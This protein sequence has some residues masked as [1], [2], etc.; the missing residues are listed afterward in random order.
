MTKHKILIG[1]PYH[2][3]MTARFHLSVINLGH[4]LYT[5]GWETD[6]YY[7]EGTILS[8]QRNK[9]ASRAVEEGSDL[10]F[11]DTDMT[12]T[13][14]DALKVM[15]IEG[16]IVGGLYYARRYPYQPLVYCE[17][18]VEVNGKFRALSL[19]DM[20]SGP[21]K[22]EGLGCGFLYIRHST[23]EKI[24][25]EHPHPFNYMDTMLGEQL[26][27]DL[28]FFHRVNKM[29]LTVICDP[30]VDV[31][32]LSDIIVKKHDHILALQKDFHYCNPI[33]GW[34]TVREQ[35]W[36]F[37][38]AQNMESIVE[39]G[40]WKGKS[41]HALC[42][43]CPGLVTAVDHF[44]GSEHEREGPHREAV[45][46]DVYEQFMSN[47]GRRFANLAVLRASS[48]EAAE[49]YSS[50]GF[51]TDMVFI[52]AGHEYDEVKK[53][54]ELWDPIATKLISGHDYTN[55]IGVQQAV[56]E[57]YERS[58]VNVF[59]SIWYVKRDES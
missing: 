2:T 38:T 54:L 33:S 3:G 9:A 12:F 42:C 51:T 39:L 15:A 56:N 43:G 30:T 4:Y 10:F 40:S 41:T 49:K 31:G 55:F 19:P 6:I 24:F 58:K 52:D 47:V 25:A 53:D 16:D 37:E 57:K 18:L 50:R 45:E 5:H 34:M 46:K 21:F 20:P 14:Q 44:M 28:A 1:I 26:G 22:C 17:D 59:E 32:H 27:E 13:P 7:S 35:N 36:L 8:S 48:E 11:L 23:L 29:G